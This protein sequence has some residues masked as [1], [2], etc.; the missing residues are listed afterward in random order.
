MAVIDVHTHW[1]PVRYRR[2]VAERG[3][4]HGLDAGAGQLAS[5]GTQMTLAERIADMD[6]VGVQMQVLSAGGGFYQYDNEL[7]TTIAIARDCNDELAEIVAEHPERFAALGT[8][9][10]QDVAAAVSEL[11]RLMACGLHGV[12][13][14][15]HVLGRTWDDSA[16]D[17]FWEAAQAR[18]AIVFFHQGFDGR[19]KVGKFSLDNSIGNLVERTLTFGTIA[20]GGVLDRFPR[21]RLL[22]AH[23]G[24][25]A[26]WAAARMDKAAGAFAPDDPAWPAREGYQSPY[27]RLAPYEAPALLAPSAYLRSFYYDSCTFSGPQLRFMIDAIGVDRIVLGTD[28]PAGMGL[29]NSVRWIRSLDCLDADEKEAILVGSPGTLFAR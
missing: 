15:D 17:P 2:A 4:W 29:T 25:Y 18:G 12:M 13:V 3:E 23:G 1:A 14:G 20:A 26:A 5:K 21:L 27:P 6:A 11:E 8:L 28:T 7:E 19:Y 16:F 24:G 22:L 10:M 9:P